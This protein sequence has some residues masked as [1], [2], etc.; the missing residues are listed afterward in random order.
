MDTI[1]DSDSRHKPNSLMRTE[2]AGNS[3]NTAL[4]GYKVVSVGKGGRRYSV[5]M[6]GVARVNY[7]PRRTA[8]PRHGCGPLAV[9]TDLHTARTSIFLTRRYRGTRRRTHPLYEL[10]ECRYTPATVETMLYSPE[11]GPSALNAGNQPMPY[12]ALATSVTLTRQLPA[13]M[14]GP[15]QEHPVVK[16][17]RRTV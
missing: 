17:R 16:S 11:Y 10:W 9:F 5:I 12:A 15:Y 14:R 6:D 1:P 4:P 13:G 3:T 7:I 2:P 8:T